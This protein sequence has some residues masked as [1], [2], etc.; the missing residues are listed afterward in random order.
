MSQIRIH[1][2]FIYGCYISYMTSLYV[3]DAAGALFSYSHFTYHSTYNYI[4]WF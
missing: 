4:G 3:E 1:T 2:L